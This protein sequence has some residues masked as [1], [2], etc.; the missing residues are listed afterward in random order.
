M[1]SAPRDFKD[2]ESIAQK[3]PEQR[4]DL[5]SY[6]IEDPHYVTE[7]TTMKKAIDIFKQMQLR[8]L[9]VVNK[10]DGTVTGMLTRQD[11]FAYMTL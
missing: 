1:D 8:Q 3:H 7:L 9:P 6:M 5:R 11:F 4:L 10:K 2:I